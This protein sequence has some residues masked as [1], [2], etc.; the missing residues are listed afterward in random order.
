MSLTKLIAPH[1]QFFTSSVSIISLFSDAKPNPA[2]PVTSSAMAM[3]GSSLVLAAEYRPSRRP[4][5]I[6]VSMATPMAPSWSVS[7]PS[8]KPNRDSDLSW[9][10]LAVARDG[11]RAALVEC[12]PEH[13]PGRAERRHQ[14]S[15]R[16]TCQHLRPPN[17]LK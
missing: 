6:M 5:P 3:E 9:W 7:E 12:L 14:K 2:A 10:S 4:D 13:H 8:V 15:R 1:N 16:K 17:G 11:L